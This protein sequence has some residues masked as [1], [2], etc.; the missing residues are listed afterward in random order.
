MKTPITIISGFA[1]TG[2]TAHLIQCLRT[3]SGKRRAVI[4]NDIAEVV[5][6]CDRV[7][8]ALQRGRDELIALPNGCICCTIDEQFIAIIGECLRRGFQHIF[9]EAN[10]TAEPS[11][12]KSMLERSPF[13]DSI[14]IQS[15]TTVIHASRFF[16][17]FRSHDDL[18]VRGM[19]ALTEDDRSVAEVL[20]EQIEHAD[21]LAIRHVEQ[22]S[23]ERLQM[24]SSLLTSVNPTAEIVSDA[25]IRLDD[26]KPVETWH[27]RASRP[28]HPDRLDAFLRG[29]ALANVL[30]AEGTAWI[31]SRQD[32]KIVW[33]QTGRICTLESDGAWWSVPEGMNDAEAKAW[34]DQCGERYQDVT[35]HGIGLQRSGLSDHLH[36][37]LL[38]HEEM[39]LGSDLWV[40]FPDEL[41][42]WENDMDRSSF[43]VPF[44]TALVR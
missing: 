14:R 2:K 11:L 21:T 35:F 4:M 6:G 43:L 7:R 24:L 28:F 38:T 20:A 19:V 27:F 16:D 10:A 25:A 36:D 37:C 17:D 23:S 44:N 33:S 29:A 40:H 18:R 31:A 26:A 12:I 8:A 15:L 30:R 5:T 42:E 39:S 3:A 22:V 1:Q 34:F 9:V 32:T 13:A 41:G